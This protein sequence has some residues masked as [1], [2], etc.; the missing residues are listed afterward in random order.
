MASHLPATS[1]FIPLKRA[2]E[3]PPGLL[4]NSSTSL[5][6]IRIGDVDE[7]KSV[8][9]GSALCNGCA[10]GVVMLRELRQ[11]WDGDQLFRDVAHRLLPGAKRVSDVNIAAIGPSGAFQFVCRKAASRTFV[12]GSS[13]A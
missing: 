6:P 11:R 9:R 12:S 2:G 5:K 7:H 8:S 10:T 3:F 13:S 4:L 1:S